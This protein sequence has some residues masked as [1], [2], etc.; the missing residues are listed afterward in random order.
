[1][2]ARWDRALYEL[3]LDWNAE[4]LGEFP[5]PPADDAGGR[6]SA[7]SRRI[8]HMDEEP[9]AGSAPVEGGEE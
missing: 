8:G 9:E 1:M 3:R 7:R 2:L 5:V 4:A 6:W